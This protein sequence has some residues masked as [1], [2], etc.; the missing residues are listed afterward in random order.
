MAELEVGEEGQSM[1]SAYAS[2]YLEQ[3]VGN[4]LSRE[5]IT[6]H[7]LRY[8]IIPRLLCEQH[9]IHVLISSVTADEC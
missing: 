4:G 6:N 2:I 5:D 7:E 1:D 8:N 9:N 3:E